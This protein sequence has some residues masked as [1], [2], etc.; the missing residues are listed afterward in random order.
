MVQRML[1]ILFLLAA[2]SPAQVVPPVF[3]NPE[4]QRYL[5]LTSAQVEE[6]QRNNAQYRLTQVATYGRINGLNDEIRLETRKNE[7]DAN[8]LGARYAE[9]ET[10]CRQAETPLREMQQRQARVLN[11][12]QRARLATLEQSQRLQGVS[13]AAEGLMLIPPRTFLP[14]DFPMVFNGTPTRAIYTASPFFVTVGGPDVTPDLVAYL[15]LSAPQLGGLRRAIARYQEFYTV[16]FGRINEVGREIQVELAGVAPNAAA[17]GARYWEMEAQRRQIAAREAETR[18]EL[19][20]L[21]TPEQHTRLAALVQPGLIGLLLAEAQSLRLIL[22]DFAARPAS[23]GSAATL[24]FGG[25]SVTNGQLSMDVTQSIYRTCL[26][27][28]EYEY[29]VLIFNPGPLVQPGAPAQG[30]NRPRTE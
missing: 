20:A 27:G 16:R 17:V 21:L 12:D 13:I 11:E 24:V 23:R 15:G 26:G 5:E 25:G 4:F 30:S 9:I 19:Q 2:L 1:P 28:P 29:R 6:I 7:P 8:A 3:V 22:T 18:S 14:S 10:L